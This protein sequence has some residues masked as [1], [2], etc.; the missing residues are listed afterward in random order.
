[1]PMKPMKILA[2]L[3]LTSVFFGCQGAKLTSLPDGLLG[4]WKTSAPKYADRFFELKREAITFGTGEGAS[5]AHDILSVEK[6]PAGKQVLYTIRYATE[7][8]KRS[9]FSFYYDPANGGTI[10]FKN[11]K[12]MEWK[13]EPPR[14]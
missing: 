6:V 9:E 2:A 7:G 4:V 8:G 13:K 11:Q 5:S 1:M 3:T 12:E 14:P 10:R